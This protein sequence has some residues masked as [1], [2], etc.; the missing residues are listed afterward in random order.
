MMA[1]FSPYPPEMLY[2][3]FIHKSFPEHHYPLEQ[4]RHRLGSLIKSIY[5]EQPYAVPKADVRETTKAFFID[6]EL[7]GLEATEKLKLTWTNSR[8]LLVEVD[9]MRP[10]LPAAEVPPADKGAEEGNEL[11]EAN[12]SSRN[13]NE[14][15]TSK[16]TS[17]DSQKVH[18]VVRERW[19]GL[20][21]RA[22]SFP[23]DVEHDALKAVLR[24]GLLRIEIPKA[25][26]TN[27][28]RSK[29]QVL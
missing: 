16:P 3:T 19:Q 27:N 23:V 17:D 12:V 25:E 6:V 5:E 22:F 10:P 28:I 26:T 29:I 8:T 7:P 1:N 24:W 20:V 11:T 13:K 2:T 14:K 15:D 18:I 9:L 21:E 4:A